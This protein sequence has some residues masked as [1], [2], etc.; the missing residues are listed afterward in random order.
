MFDL[1]EDFDSKEDLL[2]YFVAIQEKI[3]CFYKTI[4]HKKSLTMILLGFR[5]ENLG[6]FIF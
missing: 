6:N 4:F 2:I 1:D 5:I 3:N